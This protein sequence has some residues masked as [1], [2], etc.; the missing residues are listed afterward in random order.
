MGISHSWAVWGMLGTVVLLIVL[1]WVG[2]AAA[3]GR[4]IPTAYGAPISTRLANSKATS[5]AV[6]VSIR[7]LRSCD[8][9]GSALIGAVP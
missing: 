2:C 7:F 6:D 1:A 3:V 4:S 8:N 9:A 5:A